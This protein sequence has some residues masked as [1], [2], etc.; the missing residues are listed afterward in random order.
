MPA[1]RLKHRRRA[2]LA[3]V[4]G[5]IMMTQP[6]LV[7]VPAVHHAAHQPEVHASS[8]TSQRRRR[9]EACEGSD[10]NET[11]FLLSG[12]SA[13]CAD[14]FQ[15]NVCTGIELSC[16]IA[17]VCPESCAACRTSTY[18][19]WPDTGITMVQAD[20]SY[21]EAG[22]A[23][24]VPHCESTSIRVG[25]QTWGGLIRARCPESCGCGRCPPPP[26]PA[27]PHAPSC[28]A[29]LDLALVL[30]T[31]GSLLG[32][33]EQVAGFA[34]DLLLQ[35]RIASVHMHGALV[36]FSDAA[37]TLAALT[38]NASA[39]LGA[40]AA[41]PWPAGPTSISSGLRAAAAILNGST[42]AVPRVMLLV[43]DGEQS[44]Q[45]GG[46]EQ[47]VADAAATCV[48]DACCHACRRMLPA[49]DLPRVAPVPWLHW[50]GRIGLA[51]ASPQA[52]ALHQN[53][54]CRP[55]PVRAL[56]PPELGL[57]RGSHSW[58]TQPP[59]TTGGR[60]GTR[61]RVVCNRL[62]RRA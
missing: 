23:M 22:C 11:G 43:S 36:A 62:R 16:E 6:R 52:K 35:V 54:V 32:Y 21:A 27:P 58:H 29:A 4:A 28:E 8:Q 59:L 49:P 38:A 19:D 47:A 42:R 26:P 18:C 14:L 1:P 39:L 45:F 20:G 57:A 15:A 9:L 34:R 60:Q 7:F 5:H 46:A 31:S 44:G 13:S 17:T 53:R 55:A 37:V 30:D 40:V 56:R 51:F 41:V 61:Y 3:S 25:I 12:K 10:S 33:Q 24:L 2:V 48:E 50:P